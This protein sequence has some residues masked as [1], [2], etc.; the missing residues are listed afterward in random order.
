M[1]GWKLRPRGVISHIMYRKWEAKRPA[2]LMGVTVT[3]DGRVTNYESD[4][5]ACGQ[6]TSESR[7]PTAVNVRASVLRGQC[8]IVAGAP[9]P[10]KLALR[11][12]R[13]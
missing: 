9:G 6:Q 10:E 7:F 2:G 3:K 11:R 5:G 8:F 1:N 13:S 4:F 12:F